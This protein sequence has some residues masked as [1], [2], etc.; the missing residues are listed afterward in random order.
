M[1]TFPDYTVVCELGKGATATVYLAVQKSLNRRVALKVLG[2]GVAADPVFTQRFLREG[3][4]IAKLNHPHIVP[5]YDVGEQDGALF[6]AMEY[7]EGGTLDEQRGEFTLQDLSRCCEQITDALDYAHQQGFVHRDIKLENILF[8]EN[9]DAVLGDFGIARSA[10]S[11]TRMTMTGAILG[12]PAYMSPEQVAGSELDSRADLYSLGVVLFE[13]LSG[14]APFQG[15]SVMSVGL[16]HLTAPIPDLPAAAEHFQPLVESAMAKKPDDRLGTATEFRESFAERLR[17]FGR[18]GDTPLSAM[19]G[20]TAPQP[21]DIDSAL[22]ASRSSSGRGWLLGAMGT[23]AAAALA[24]VVFQE[25]RPESEPPASTVMP[26]P[27]DLEAQR[28]AEAIRELLQQADE[29]D[30]A[31]RWFSENGDGAVDLYREVLTRDGENAAATS[32][33]QRARRNALQ[34]A[35]L[36]VLAGRLE[37]AESR[38]DIIELNWPDD[39][40]VASLRTDIEERRSSLASAAAREERNRRLANSL[41]RASQAARLG[42]WVEPENDN[43]LTLYRSALAIDPRNA[44]ALAGIDSVATHFIN[45]AEQAIAN[46]QFD[47]ATQFLGTAASVDADHSRLAMVGERL[48]A[49]TNAVEERRQIEEAA[50]RFD[51]KIADLSQR[52]DDYI[53]GRTDENEPGYDSLSADLTAL[54]AEDPENVT[55]QALRNAL[56]SYEDSLGDPEEDGKRFNLPTF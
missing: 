45:E 26:E 27:V 31:G 49:A 22:S 1:R 11:L 44:I 10:E 2:G 51:A 52:I 55:V 38:L 19:H 30:Q 33:L 37:D 6:M 46:E 13:L 36:D 24:F 35:E 34:E 25:M 12:T 14:H 54:S 32:G 20:D 18:P 40:T 56:D 47:L 17:S 43:A 39:E 4:I 48:R 50:R 15:D 23:A 21:L 16:Q 3:R 28:V 8:R 41:D 9:G 29:A 5:V 53:N 42:N 7:L